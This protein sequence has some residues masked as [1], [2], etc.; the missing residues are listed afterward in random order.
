MTMREPINEL[1]AEI[2][3]VIASPPSRPVRLMFMENEILYE[4]AQNQAKELF[5]QNEI[6]NMSDFMKFHAWQE[7]E[8]YIQE[9]EAEYGS[10]HKR[11]R[12]AVCETLESVI[13]EFMDKNEAAKVLV[14][15]D[16]LLSSLNFDPIHFLLAY[17]TE[18]QK[19]VNGSIPLIWL[20]IGI[21]EEYSENEYCYFKTETAPGRKVKVKQSTLTACVKDYRLPD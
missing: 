15:Q 2:K 1:I 4:M 20:T 19:I 17:M 5:G 21:K 9:I 14:I 10:E 3:R 7:R 6:L 13:N 12:Q 8:G 11:Y 16:A 18:N